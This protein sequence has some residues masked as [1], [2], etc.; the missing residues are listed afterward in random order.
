MAFSKRE[1]LAIAKMKGIVGTYSCHAGTRKPCGKCV[2]CLEVKKGEL[3][4]FHMGGKYSSGRTLSL[5]DFGNLKDVAKKGANGPADLTSEKK[6]FS[7]LCKRRSDRRE[8]AS[9]PSEE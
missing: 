4:R 7:E 8:S 9:R 1:V 6:C 2:S 5:G 3:R